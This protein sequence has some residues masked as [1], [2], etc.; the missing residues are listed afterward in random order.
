LTEIPEHL[1]RRSRERRAA[2]GSGGGE[3]EP[4]APSGEAAA[5]TR[6]AGGGG[7]ASTPSTEVAVP[8][9]ASPAVVGPPPDEALPTYIAVPK[10]PHKTKVPLW[11]M[12][13]LVAIPL[14]AFLFPGAFG[15]HQKAAVSTDPLVIGNQ[16]YHSAGCSGCHGANGEGGVGPALHGG[17][18]VLTF[19]N[20]ADQVSWVK[21][22]SAPFTGKKYGDPG[23]AGGQR[24]PA[25]GGMPAF[26]TSLSQSQIEAVVTYERTKL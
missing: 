25:T 16:V 9:G 13:V 15:N 11:V 10:G 5:P 6:S 8:G 14:W 2:L 26:A 21:T 19:P 24:G 22:G 4:A 12:P 20:V 3:G 17:Q 1:L 18:A 7:A 23:R